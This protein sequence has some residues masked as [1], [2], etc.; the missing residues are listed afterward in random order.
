[1]TSEQKAKSQQSGTVIIGLGIMWIALAIAIVALQFAVPA[2]VD[3]EWETETEIETAGFNIYRS[4]TRDG[5]YV[6]IN[7]Q[8]IPSQ[9]D[10]VAGAT[11]LY[12]DTD[13]TRGQTYYYRLEDIEFDNSTNQHDILIG[14]VEALNWWT[15]PLALFSGIVGIM[16]VF[17]GVRQSRVPPVK[18]KQNE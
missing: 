10:A 2:K 18:D 5:E 11:Y 13:V 17:S 14:E 1:M 3:I 15:I 8:I 6:R 12:S 7:E 9:S 4:D 16:M